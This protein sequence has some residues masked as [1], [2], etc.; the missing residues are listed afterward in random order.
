MKNQSIKRRLAGA[1]RRFRH[2]NDNTGIKA[3][4][5]Q[6]FVFAYDQPEAD[7]VVL[8]LLNKLEQS[9]SRVMMLECVLGDT[10]VNME[11]WASYAS[12]HFIE[13]HDLAGDLAFVAKALEPGSEKAWRLGQETEIPEPISRT[14][15]HHDLKTD[16]KVF[17]ESFAGHKPWEV[18]LNDRDFRVGDSVT[19]HETEFTGDEMAAGAT[20]RYTGRT[21]QGV[22]G[23]VL[24]G[25]LY[26][27][28]S[29]W[30]VFSLM[31]PDQPITDSERA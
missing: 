1:T 25:P 13:K 7:G 30:C 26:G 6:G 11:D 12:E 14:G 21:V 27:I 22:I 31:S 2:E 24:N 20:L 4:P 18:R 23:L 28:A 29:N 19:L 15:T 10:A 9:Q 17:R 3:D 8:E 16:H 5:E